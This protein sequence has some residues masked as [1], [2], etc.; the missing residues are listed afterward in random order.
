LEETKILKYFGLGPY[1]Y[2]EFMRIVVWLIFL[3][4]LLSGVIIYINSKS[5]GLSNYS[6]SF[7]TYLITT[8]LGISIF[9]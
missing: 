6:T 9:T 3:A 8:T 7:S 4:S 5:S 1:F 2:I